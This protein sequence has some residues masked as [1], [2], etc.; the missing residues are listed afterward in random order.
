MLCSLPSILQDFSTDN[1]EKGMTRDIPSGQILWETGV[2]SPVILFCY[3]EYFNIL[4][5]RTPHKSIFLS[6]MEDIFFEKNLKSQWLISFVVG[7]YVNA[8][9]KLR[10]GAGIWIYACFWG[11][12]RPELLRLA[13][14]LLQMDLLLSHENS[15][16][17][18][19]KISFEGLFS[20][21]MCLYSLSLKQ[22]LMLKAGG[23]S[24]QF[25]S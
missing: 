3:Q 8:F 7:R 2:I 1:K 20:L 18:D 13:S 22:W 24:W 5:K 17:Q 10:C 12:V 6:S 23:N 15:S 14:F 19:F 4:L 9:L 11:D 21:E 25:L 16:A